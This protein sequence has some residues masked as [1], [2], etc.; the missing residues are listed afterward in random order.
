MSTHKK[1]LIKMK[2]ALKKLEEIKTKEVK[3]NNDEGNKRVS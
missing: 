3:E 2:K 1:N